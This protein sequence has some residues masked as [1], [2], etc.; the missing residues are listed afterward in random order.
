MSFFNPKVKAGND[1]REIYEL[2]D[3]NNFDILPRIG[4][5]G[6][7]KLYELNNLTTGEIYEDLTY[8]EMLDIIKG[9]VK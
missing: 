8:N 3:K 7:L 4:E 1:M 6:G 9:N 2:A 5:V